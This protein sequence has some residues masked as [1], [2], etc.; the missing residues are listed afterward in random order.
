MTRLVQVKT[1]QTEDDHQTLVVMWA[2]AAVGL[3]PA[4]RWLLHVPNERKCTPAQGARLKRIGVKRGVSDLFLPHP[5]G[6]YA[7][8]W[9]EM[10]TP[11][12]RPTDDQTQFITAMRREGYAARV[13]YG[14]EDAIRTLQDYL[15]GVDLDGLS[16]TRTHGGTP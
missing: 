4:L 13:C 3:Y 16:D 12:G 5:V 8:L 15:K 6:R 11:T 7:G 1:P 10:K 14:Y 9:I 2:N